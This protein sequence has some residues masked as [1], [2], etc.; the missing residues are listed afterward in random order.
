MLI[1][2]SPI[3]PVAWIPADEPAIDHDAWTDRAGYFGIGPDAH[4]RLP[5]IKPGE[6]PFCVWFKPISHGDFLR[7]QALISQD[8][9][10]FESPAVLAEIL[11]ASVVRIEGAAEEVGGKVQE[12]A[13]ERLVGPN[14]ITEEGLNFFSHPALALEAAAAAWVLSLSRFS[15][16]RT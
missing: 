5:P 15:R 4:F 12:I 14:G 7:I 6:R 2:T 1:R 3:E 13:P 9:K 11:R 8:S 10:A 16:P